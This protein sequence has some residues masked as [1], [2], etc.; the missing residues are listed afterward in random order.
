LP[1][2]PVLLGEP[3][4]PA[5]PVVPEPVALVLPVLP[6]PDAVL[7]PPLDCETAGVAMATASAAPAMRT[8][9]RISKLLLSFAEA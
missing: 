3:L 6:L 8:R 4:L 7:P 2:G 9:E 5:D 1:A